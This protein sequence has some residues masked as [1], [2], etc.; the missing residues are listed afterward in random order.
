M[1]Q[2]DLPLIV[3]AIDAPRFFLGVRQRGKQ[4]TGKNRD[5]GDDDEKFDQRK[6][7]ASGMDPFAS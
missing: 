5:D 6:A 2:R 7:N 3:H 1:V 4:Q